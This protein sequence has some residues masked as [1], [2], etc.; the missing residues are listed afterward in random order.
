MF[1]LL[2]ELSDSCEG[3]KDL[4]VL[5]IIDKF[6]LVKGTRTEQTF[7]L[8]GLRKWEDYRQLRAS[9]GVSSQVFQV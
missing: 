2:W 1:K 6:L 7:V 3:I 8:K 5:G 9:L 4:Q